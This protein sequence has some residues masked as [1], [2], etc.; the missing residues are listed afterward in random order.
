MPWVP[1]E[2]ENWESMIENYIDKP[3]LN[4]TLEVSVNNLYVVN[5][6]PDLSI[7]IS[8]S[9]NKGQ[10]DTEI[11]DDEDELTETELKKLMAFDWSTI[12]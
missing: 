5:S 8:E 1:D 7:V 9:Q 11:I 3:L 12:K 4:K 6:S 10:I 2:L